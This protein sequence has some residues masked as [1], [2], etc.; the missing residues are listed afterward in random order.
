MLLLA[1]SAATTHTAQVAILDQLL[2]A[3]ADTG[4]M[5]ESLDDRAEQTRTLMSALISKLTVCVTSNLVILCVLT[6]IAK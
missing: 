6:K 5:A 2:D 4:G 3:W 1:N